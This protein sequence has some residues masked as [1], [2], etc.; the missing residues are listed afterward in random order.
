[1]RTLQYY[2]TAGFRSLSKTRPG[3]GGIPCKEGRY[4]RPYII[5]RLETAFILQTIA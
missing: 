2:R 1:M 5:R 4:S 3:A